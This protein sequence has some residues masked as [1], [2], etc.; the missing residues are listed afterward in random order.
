MTKSEY[1]EVC[2]CDKRGYLAEKAKEEERVSE[3]AQDRMDQ[4]NQVG[5]C[6]KEFFAG[7]VEVTRENGSNAMIEKTLELIASGDVKYIAEATFVADGCYCQADV[8]G[9]NEDGTLDVYEVKSSASIKEYHVLDMTFQQYVINRAGFEVKN[10]YHM[11]IDSKYVRG[12]ELDVQ[13]LFKVTDVTEK[14]ASKQEGMKE[15][16]DRCKGI[17]TS[18]D[19][20]NIDIGMHCKQPVECPY[21]QHCTK[22]L[23]KNNVFEISG[24]TFNKKMALYKR[25][26]VT[27]EDIQK[28]SPKEVTKAK[29]EQ[30]NSALETKEDVSTNVLALQEFLVTAYG[31]IYFVDFETFQQVI[32]MWEG[33]SPYNQIPFQYS[34]HIKSEK[35]L[36]HK[37]FLAEEGIDPRREFAERLCND[38]P[39]GVVSVAYNMAFEKMV[40]KKLA[41]LFPDLEA[42]LL[43]I[44]E[45]MIDLMKPFQSG[46]Y[47]QANFGG[48]YSIKAVLPGLFPDDESLNY[49]NLS[50]FV[51]NGQ[52]AMT[53]YA[54]LANQKNKEHRDEIRAALIE[55]CKLD[56]YA[57]VRIFEFLEELVL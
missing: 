4:G 16:V 28:N 29:M 6:A 38:I 48:S 14:I 42:H 53:A 36:E 39:M 47:R 23:P 51:Q 46:H 33:V 49:G 40:M 17:K 35:G 22:H 18:G 50:D 13:E 57:M 34:L 44:C 11:G 19:E 12:K 8:I 9:V 43:D 7:C 31:D 21:F 24:M 54:E 10:F 52:M 15:E 37:E 30:V 25:G 26:I 56:T 2:F 3:K 32:P 55:Y 20:P 41:E 5:D 27:F 45:N 1:L